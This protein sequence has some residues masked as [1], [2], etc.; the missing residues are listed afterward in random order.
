M[1]NVCYVTSFRNLNI[2]EPMKEPF[3]L[4]SGVNIT[5]DI[6]V[7]AQFLNDEFR[8]AA[9]LIEA[10]T[11]A[12]ENNLVFGEF[13]TSE[14]QDLPPEPFLLVILL[15]IDILLRNAWLVKDH[16]MECDAIFLRVGT[17]SGTSWTRN[18]LAM[19][20]SL[21]DGTIAAGLDMSL[22]ELQTWARTSDSVESYLHDTNS[23]SLQFMLAKT[24]R[25]SGR[26]IQYVDAARKSANLAFKIAHYCSALETLFTTEATELAHKLSERVAFFLGERG[27]D[28]WAV[29]STIKN[30]Y[31][32]RSKLVHGDTLKAAQIEEL[33]LISQQCDNYLRLI[34]TSIFENVELKKVFDSEPG[35]IEEYF[36]RLIFGSPTA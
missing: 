22:S 23:S 36:A 1:K 31:N 33:H 18:F 4:L 30:A 13:D 17:E 34:L 5:N 12:S 19:R 25:R 2:S 10:T 29:F 14:M 7:K 16:S 11:L 32:V 24:F 15:W 6:S 28:R 3:E 26:A 21:A 9:G 35:A 20:P 8:R 27:Y